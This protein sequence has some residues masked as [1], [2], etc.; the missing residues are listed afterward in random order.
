MIKHCPACGAPNQLDGAK[1]CVHCGDRFPI[2]TSFTT[3]GPNSGG[4]R[5]GDLYGPSNEVAR[6]E[7]P[8]N[9]QTGFADPAY[10]GVSYGD[11]SGYGA[12]PGMGPVGQ[13]VGVAAPL[14]VV[15]D[16]SQQQTADRKRGLSTLMVGSNQ[17]GG[18]PMDFP[19]PIPGPIPGGRPGY[20]D[21]D[22]TMMAGSP[23]QA[24]GY[25]QLIEQQ[26]A[27]VSN[28]PAGAF[29]AQG[30][31][32][33]TPGQHVPGQH[34]Q[35]QQYPGQHVPGHRMPAQHMPMHHSPVQHMPV[36]HPGQ[37]V[38]AEQ[39]SAQQMSAQQMSAQQMPAQQIPAQ[40]MPAQQVP[41]SMVQQWPGSQP[42]HLGQ[43]NSWSASAQLAAE[44][45]RDRSTHAW[46]QP[47]GSRAGASQVAGVVSQPEQQQWSP[48]AVVPDLPNGAPTHQP[49]AVQS[50]WYPP[51]DRAVRVR[52][53]HPQ[54][55]P[56]RDEFGQQ[57]W[58]ALPHEAGRVDSVGGTPS[59]QVD[60]YPQ[61]FEA[62]VRDSVRSSFSAVSPSASSHSPDGALE[63]GA[64]S[65][66]P[67]RLGDVSMDRTLPSE[68][69]P[70]DS[71]GSSETPGT[72]DSPDLPGFGAS[73]SGGD[74]EP[75]SEWPLSE[76]PDDS[77]LSDMTGLADMFG[78]GSSMVSSIAAPA[79]VPSV[80]PG[81]SPG[82]TANVFV[83]EQEIGSSP[84]LVP[85]PMSEPMP[86]P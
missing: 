12:V 67:G 30:P 42:Q 84:T 15:G 85:E 53:S 79:V 83:S 40:Q 66:S 51:L 69:F 38:T 28:R 62:D 17:L 25:N 33:Q 58:S 71:P 2:E 78:G 37:H 3:E 59:P 23:P 21:E 19:P 20:Y 7:P 55:P 47:S 24:P 46:D 18:G 45:Q 75:L 29:R 26:C 41:P 57:R 52:E 44:G 5:P 16:T 1:F 68:W 56:S 36:H 70:S 54:P 60:R 80:V 27:M 10:G 86:E 11:G 73:M 9:A 6:G 77:D 81:S 65:A 82:S 48:Q 72:A 63:R 4:I 39:M 43:Q 50:R 31:G 13:P 22:A 49:T 8:E 35:R 64:H 32:P 34:I 14:G 61:R 76:P 74:S